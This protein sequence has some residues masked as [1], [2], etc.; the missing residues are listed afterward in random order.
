MLEFWF[1][2]IKFML[3]CFPA[4]MIILLPLLI[5][6]GMLFPWDFAQKTLNSSNQNVLILVGVT[7]SKDNLETYYES[8]ALL[9]SVFTDP[10]LYSVGI[11]KDGDSV[12]IK[13]E[14]GFIYILIV[15]L[16]FGYLTY[17]FWF[18]RK[19]LITSP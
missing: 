12:V 8:Y 18:K 17:L 4:L 13:E 11:D 9:P 14:Y 16:L 7:G 3:K 10:S 5:F 19:N 15:Y 1:K 2:S 6:K